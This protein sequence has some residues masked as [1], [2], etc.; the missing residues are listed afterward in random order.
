MTEFQ[1]SVV[2]VIENWF[3]TM[4]RGRSIP[5]YDTAVIVS[6]SGGKYTINIDGNLLTNIPKRDSLSV[7][8]NDVVYVLTPTGKLEDYIIDMKKP[9]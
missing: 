6:S 2:T 8:I 4:M 7:N 5:Q 1:N 9:S 3:K